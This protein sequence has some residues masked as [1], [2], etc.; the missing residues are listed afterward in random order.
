MTRSSQLSTVSIRAAVVLASLAVASCAPPHSLQQ[1]KTSNPTVTYEYRGDQEL[2]QAQQS[3]VT[4]CGQ[5]DAAPRPARIT[6]G[7]DGASNNV[8]FECGP[9]LPTAALP[10]QT[11]D[12][13]LSYNYRTDQEL[14]DASQSAQTYCMNNGS[15]RSVSNIATN[16][17]GSRTVM[18]QCTRG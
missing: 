10:R 12:P 5:Y 13:D 14:L 6:S 2:L 16:P 4:F 9:S 17:D 3:A 8:L 11:S 1:V 15:Q 18:F 7:P